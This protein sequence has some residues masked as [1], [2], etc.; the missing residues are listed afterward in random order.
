MKKLQDNSFSPSCYDKILPVV[1]HRNTDV[2]LYEDCGI[3]DNLSVHSLAHGLAA[4]S[5]KT[6]WISG[7]MVSCGYLTIR[8]QSGNTC[9]NRSNIQG[10]GY[11]EY[12]LRNLSWKILANKNPPICIPE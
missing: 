1:V 6:I 10:L 4:T 12:S 5:K 11:G 2:L 7:S 8:T 9:L 3:V